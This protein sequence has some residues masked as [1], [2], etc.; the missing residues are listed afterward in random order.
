MAIPRS[1]KKRNTTEIT[2]FVGKNYPHLHPRTDTTREKK[3]WSPPAPSSPPRGGYSRH[4]ARLAS[5]TVFFFSAVGSAPRAP[6]PPSIQPPSAALRCL[7]TA[8]SIGPTPRACSWYDLHKHASGMHA[9]P[10]CAVW[11]APQGILRRGMIVV[12]WGGFPT[13]VVV[14]SRGGPLLVYLSISVLPWRVYLGVIVLW[15]AVECMYYRF[16][17][18]CVYIFGQLVLFCIVSHCIVLYCLVVFYC[19]V[20]SCIVLCIDCKIR[21]HESNLMR[22][23]HMEEV[24]C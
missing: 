12:C 10:G 8:R 15:E 14:L 7:L 13:S 3:V 23:H 9:P 4:V 5:P 20:L 17:G 1:P 6:P 24:T 2:P 11:A 16:S 19:I 21:L 18:F 22:Q